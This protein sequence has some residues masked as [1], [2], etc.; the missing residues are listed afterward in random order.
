M[1]SIQPAAGLA[2]RSAAATPV[3]V[4]APAGFVWLL[5]TGVLAVFLYYLIGV[6]QGMVA[7]FGAEGQVHEFVH[8]ARHLLGFPCH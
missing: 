6:E 5:G 1:S 2:P 7:M 8:D 4:C 3:V